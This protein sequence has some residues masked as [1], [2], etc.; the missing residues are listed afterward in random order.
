MAVLTVAASSFN[1]LGLLARFIIM[2]LA[3]PTTL[4]SDAHPLYR[5]SFDCV[6][7]MF[8]NCTMAALASPVEFPEYTSPMLMLY[9]QLKLNQGAP[10]MAAVAACTCAGVLK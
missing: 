3:C 8:W 6:T 10:Y 2:P 7:F 9:V 5:Y 4:Y 1:A